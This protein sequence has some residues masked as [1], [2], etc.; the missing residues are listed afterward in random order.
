M[1]CRG[2]VLFS[3]NTF[4]F[5]PRQKRSVACT[6]HLRALSVSAPQG[7]ELGGGAARVP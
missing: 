7:G 4:F 2:G 1:S 3:Q 6:Q 5:N